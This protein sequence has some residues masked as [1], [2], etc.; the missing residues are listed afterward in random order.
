MPRGFSALLIGFIFQDESDLPRW[1]GL[2]R[3][4]PLGIE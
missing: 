4:G 1:I 3:P 2:L